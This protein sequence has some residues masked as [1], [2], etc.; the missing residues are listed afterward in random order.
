M[1]TAFVYETEGAA[2]KDA[3][4]VERA[5]DKTR[6]A[7]ALQV[8]GWDGETPRA[9]RV[10]FMPDVQEWKR[11]ALE[12]KVSVASKTEAPARL[13][14][15]TEESFR[16]DMTSQAAGE[17]AGKR[18]VHRGNGS[19]YVMDGDQVISGPFD[20]ERAQQEAAG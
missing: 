15:T 17:P 6:R 5:R 11:T 12:A 10:E 9:D 7:I 14:E 19:Y 2:A 1:L 13:P 3:A 8:D 18:A 4:A 16:R 20:K